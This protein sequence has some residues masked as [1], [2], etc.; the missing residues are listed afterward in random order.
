MVAA[1]VVGAG[2]IGAG[3][4]MVAGSEAASG[5]KSAAQTES[6][7]ATQNENNVLAAGRQASQMDLGAIGSANSPLQPY[8]NLGNQATGTLSNLLSGQNSGQMLQALQ[9]MPGYQFL[10]KQGLEATQNGFAAKGLGSSGA[11]MKGAANYANG[12]AANNYETFYNNA[13]SD[14]QLG[15]SAAASQSQNIANLNQ[16]A[17]N[18]LMGGA[19]GAASLGMAG[20][21]A[22]ASGQVGAAN[23]LGG[24]ISNAGNTIGQALTANALLNNSRVGNPLGISAASDPILA[25]SAP[26][27]NDLISQGL[28][29]TSAFL[30]MQASN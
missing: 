7:A 25:A 18:A 28:Y 23:A 8:V 3:A 27:M 10:L 13:L 26:T 11:A 17:A 1:A 22:T 30:P 9:S 19:T 29:S 14:A 6:D 12:L 15:G 20:A 21:A 16:A 2:V 24:S 4:S 5:A